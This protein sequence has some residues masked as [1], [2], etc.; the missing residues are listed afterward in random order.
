MTTTKLSVEHIQY[1]SGVQ[2]AKLLSKDPA[3]I[4]H[5]NK[6]NFD[7]SSLKI[8]YSCIDHETLAIGLMRRK[9]DAVKTRQLQKE[10]D[11][12]LDSSQKLE[13]PLVA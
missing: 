2:L 12:I 9:A 5:W 6:R 1:A 4:C 11:E 13:K 10:F 7:L 3:V 8:Y